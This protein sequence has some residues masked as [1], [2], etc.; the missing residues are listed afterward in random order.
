VRGVAK[1]QP[2]LSSPHWP[3]R[4]TEQGWRG[5]TAH[6]AAEWATVVT[7]RQ[8]CPDGSAAAVRVFASWPADLLC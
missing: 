1:E 7:G 6:A 8:R 2:A 3:G 4:W 5:W